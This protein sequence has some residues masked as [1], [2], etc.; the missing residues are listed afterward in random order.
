MKT[1]H[2]LAYLGNLQDAAGW[3]LAGA[4]AVT[5]APGGEA[6]ALD[7]HDGHRVGRADEH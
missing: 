5:P 7:R 6:P 2:A 3:R 4:Y 1:S